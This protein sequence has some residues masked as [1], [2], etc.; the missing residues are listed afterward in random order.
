M[1]VLS[2]AVSRRLCL[3]MQRSL[4]GSSEPVDGDVNKWPIWGKPQSHPLSPPSVIK[5]S[6]F[7]EL[8]RHPRTGLPTWLQSSSSLRER[9]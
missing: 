1:G 4:E 3:K 2:P 9:L 6:L 8:P 7:S 5:F